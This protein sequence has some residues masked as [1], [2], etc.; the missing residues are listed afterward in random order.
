MI[1]DA[2][3]STLYPSNVNYNTRFS[4]PTITRE[5]IQFG[6]VSGSNWGLT[7][8]DGRGSGS[9]YVP[10]VALTTHEEEPEDDSAS[11]EASDDM[12]DTSAPQNVLSSAG[13]HK[14]LVD[15]IQVLV[16]P[17]RIRTLRSIKQFVKL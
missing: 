7:S 10:R 8:L 1:A 17:S 14:S 5:S 3:Y 15:L 4:P 13:R 9:A 2:S 12:A 6:G 11:K 16:A